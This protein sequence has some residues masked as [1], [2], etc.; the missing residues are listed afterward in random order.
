[1]F[2][3]MAWRNIW[4]NKRRSLITAASVSFA[5]F[6]AIVLRSLQLGTYERAYAGVI[7]STTGYLQVH[8]KG[9]WEQ[10]IL[11]HSLALTDSIHHKLQREEGVIDYLPR[12][13]SFSLLSGPAG[14]TKGG[15]VR[16]LQPKLEQEYFQIQEKLHAGRLFKA[17]EPAVVLGKRLA[18]YLDLGI[19][20]TLV[21]IGQGYHG[22]S[23]NGKYAVCGIVDLM[24][25]E[26]NRQVVLMP[27]AEAQYLYGAPQRATS[28]VI[29]PRDENKLA[30]LKQ[31]L[32]SQIDTTRFELMTWREMMPELVQAIEADSAGGLVILFILYLVISFGVFGTILMLTAERMPE[33]GILISIGM[34]RHRVAMVTFLET[35]FLA[36]LGIAAGALA[37]LPISWY[38]HLNPIRLTGDLTQAME[39][40]GFEPIIPF[41][42]DPSIWYV[43]GTGVLIISVLLSLYAIFKIYQLKP[44]E[45][46]R[47]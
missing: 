41:S 10:Q 22:V 45:A 46:T 25:P 36:L 14:E 32:Q 8:Q 39:D 17:R 26:M 12:L 13:E 44:V 43:H 24:N 33:F 3:K 35:L 6:F 42:V 21:M 47:T 16:G 31:K 20:D 30:P 29:I 40:Y 11:E 1:M 23:A 28:L 15:L 34:S 37:A 4:R 19:N 5:L 2:V 27:L 18:E 7:N 38:F 9:Y